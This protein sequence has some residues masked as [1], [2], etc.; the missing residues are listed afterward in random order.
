MVIAW[1]NF[2]NIFSRPHFTIIFRPEMLKFHLYS[3][4]TGD[5][6]VGSVIFCVLNKGFQRT[7]G[8]STSMPKQNY[9]Y[10]HSGRLQIHG[11]MII[12]KGLQ[13]LK[14]KRKPWIEAGDK[15]MARVLD[16]GKS[17]VVQIKNLHSSYCKNG[18]K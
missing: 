4:L 3:I 15:M 16:G 11:F 12:C 13:R 9:P 8:K 1:R 5:T 10:M 7:M 2:K 14:T 17:M 18:L 6:M